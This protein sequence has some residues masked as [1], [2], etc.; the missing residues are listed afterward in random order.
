MEKSLFWPYTLHKGSPAGYWLYCPVLKMLSFHSSCVQCICPSSRGPSRI[1][2]NRIAA[3]GIMQKCVAIRT[4]FIKQPV[5]SKG[6]FVRYSSLGCNFHLNILKP[7]FNHH[8]V[9]V[10]SA[11]ISQINS[12][13]SKFHYF[14]FSLKEYIIHVQFWLFLG[15]FY[16]KVSGDYILLYMHG[17]GLGNAHK[18][19]SYSVP[20]LNTI[21]YND[22][23]SRYSITG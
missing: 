10:R 8:E 22:M 7:T 19:I 11:A 20:N 4:I 15:H 9:V 1:S 2:W 17:Y 14:N 3:Y 23:V 13:F 16:Q 21:G 18:N 6:A 5:F 12:S